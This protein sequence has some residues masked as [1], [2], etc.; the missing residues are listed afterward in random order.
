MDRHGAIEFVEGAGF[1][2]H[3]WRT[4]G[5]ESYLRNRPDGFTDLVRFPAAEGRPVEVCTWVSHDDLSTILSPLTVE[6]VKNALYGAIETQASF[7]TV[8]EKEAIAEH[9]RHA[10]RQ[11]I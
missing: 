5:Y 9:F 6:M 3:H 7:L 4:D 1:K 10:L 2:R 11:Q 8:A